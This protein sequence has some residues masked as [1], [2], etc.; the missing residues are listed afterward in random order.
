M[1]GGITI[2]LS[3]SDVQLV[4]ETL[5]SMREGNSQL[6]ESQIIESAN[7]LIAQAEQNAAPEFVKVRLV[8]LRNLV[9]ML[10]DNAW[11]LESNDRKHVLNVVAYLGN[12]QDLIPDH[13]PVFGFFDDAIAIELCLQELSAEL[14][15][16]EN[17]CEYRHFECV[18]RNLD[19]TQVHRA[20]WLQSR[21]DELMD[22]IRRSHE[23][24]AGFGYG[25]SSGYGRSSYTAAQ[26]YWRANAY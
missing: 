4:R 9:A 26:P 23:R 10:N 22:G 16:Y 24:E 20:D 1:K 6:H 19:A 5:R 3:A 12:A 11:R 18:R 8:A 14:L 25:T 15:A 21:R 7:Q 2:Q 13:I 17:F